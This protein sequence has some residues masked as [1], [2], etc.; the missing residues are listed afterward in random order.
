MCRAGPFG[1]GKFPGEMPG[2]SGGPGHLGLS[3]T[4]AHLSWVTARS[5]LSERSPDICGGR[6]AP[7]ATHL[8]NSMGRD[9]RKAM[10]KAAAWGLLKEGSMAHYTEPKLDLRLGATVALLLHGSVSYTVVQQEDEG[11]GGA[12]RTAAALPL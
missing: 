9:I 12:D 2:R 6:R 1:C 8:P 3:W 4:A 7:Q 11:G 5:L 10:K